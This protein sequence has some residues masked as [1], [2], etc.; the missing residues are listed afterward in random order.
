MS[1]TVPS[2]TNSYQIPNDDAGPPTF[3]FEKPD[4][5]VENP[6]EPVPGLILIPTF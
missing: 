4:V 3:V 1:G 5:D 2:S 6:P